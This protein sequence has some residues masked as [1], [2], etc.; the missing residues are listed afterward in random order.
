MSALE[1]GRFIEKW[2][3]KRPKNHPDRNFMTVMQQA[4]GNYEINDPL[5][6]ISRD[7]LIIEELISEEK[8]ISPSVLRS[9]NDHLQALNEM[10]G[11]SSIAHLL[12]IEYE[13]FS[14]V[15]S[16]L[17]SY[18]IETKEKLADLKMQHINQIVWGRGSHTGVQ[19]KRIRM[20]EVIQ[21]MSNLAGTEIDQKLYGKSSNSPN[22]L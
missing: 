5:D 12:P 6:P 4:V 10:H 17:S 20:Q 8:T 22:P 21:A 14:R 19:T 1:F 15:I 16:L 3:E 7:K 2:L 18:R 13:G 11:E 9:H